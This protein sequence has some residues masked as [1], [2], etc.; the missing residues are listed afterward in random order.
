MKNLILLFT[1]F[2]AALSFSQEEKNKEQ[3]KIV[4][5]FLTNCAEKY[6]YTIQMAEWQECLDNGLKKDSTIA[7]LW[8]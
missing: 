4:E 7:Y 6:N 5:E 8:Q 1:L 2:S 3:E